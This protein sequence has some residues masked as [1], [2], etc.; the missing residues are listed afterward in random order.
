MA[1]EHKENRGSM[2]KNEDKE[3]PDSKKPDFTG[4][5]KINGEKMYVA[6]WMD[7]TKDGKAYLSLSFSVPRAGESFVAEKKLPF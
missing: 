4:S 3:D 7:E 5:A 2:F 6:A 1:Y